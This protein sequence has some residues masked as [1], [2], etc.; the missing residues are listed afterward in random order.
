MCDV[1]TCSGTYNCDS[2]AENIIRY[3]KF[4]PSINVIPWD[5]RWTSNK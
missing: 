5:Y 1:V 3:Y 2:L 4:I